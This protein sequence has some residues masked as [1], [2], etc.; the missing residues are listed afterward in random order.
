MRRTGDGVREVYVAIDKAVGE[1]LDELAG[2][3][4]TVVLIDLHG[5]SFMAGAGIVLSE[6][7]ERLGHVKR[8]PPP[9]PPGFAQ[10]TFGPFWRALP[11]GRARRAGAAQARGPGSAAAAQS[12]GVLKPQFIPGESRCFWLNLGP[13]R[14]RHPAQRGRGG[15]RPASSLPQD[16]EAFI[17][18]LTEELLAL[19]E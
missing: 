9:P 11:G 14:E 2:P 6:V 1:I 7:L 3:E 5:M 10:R 12:P 15:K 8:V 17:A 13:E 18:T 19:H 16:V 4:T